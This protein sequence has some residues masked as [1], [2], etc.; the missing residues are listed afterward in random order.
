MKAS[1]LK[2]KGIKFKPS[3]KEIVAA[4]G[5]IILIIVTP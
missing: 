5:P 2:N 1:E 4:V 3:D